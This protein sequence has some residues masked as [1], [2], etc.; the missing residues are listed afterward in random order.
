MSE[1][2]IDPSRFSFDFKIGDYIGGRFS[3]SGKEITPAKIYGDNRQVAALKQEMKIAASMINSNEYHREQLRLR[4]V[5]PDL[6]SFR[7]ESGDC[8]CGHYTEN[9]KEIIGS[10]YYGD[11][12]VVT[13]KQNAISNHALHNMG[14]HD[15]SETPT[16]SN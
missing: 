15:Y 7:F 13:K 9:G 16:K 11:P 2:E 10:K 14:H 8:I 1:I 4:E 6:S 3:K 5:S 12:T